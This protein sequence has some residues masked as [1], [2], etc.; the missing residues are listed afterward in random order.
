ME[1]YSLSSVF[2]AEW[3]SGHLVWP[4]DPRLESD[5]PQ[6]YYEGRKKMPA[7][8][9]TIRMIANAAISS[10]QALFF[11]IAFFGRLK[12]STGHDCST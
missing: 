3:R 10:N 8:T 1:T 6:P 11:G 5:L 4:E 7:D 2:H 12:L 9:R